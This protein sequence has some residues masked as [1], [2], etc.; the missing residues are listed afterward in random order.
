MNQVYLIGRVGKDPDFKTVGSKNTSLATF[1]MATSKN[2]GNF[3]NPNWES[4]WHNIK[5]W[6]KTADSVQANVRKGDEV[7]VEG[8]ITVESWDDKNGGGKVYR[9]YIVA[10]TVR[11]T[12]AADDKGPQDQTQQYANDSSW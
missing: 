9:N 2:I 7:F 8:E 3:Q 5:C 6:S 10:K 1:S 4:T 12:K 11:V